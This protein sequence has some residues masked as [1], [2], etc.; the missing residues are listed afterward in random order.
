MFS[1]SFRIAVFFVL[2]SNFCLAQ[3][4][5]NNLGSGKAG[6]LNGI[7]TTFN[8]VYAL[9]GNQSGIANL[10]KFGAFAFAEQRFLLDELTGVTAGVVIPTKAGNFGATLGYFG[11]ETLSEQKIGLAYARKLFKNLSIGGQFDFFNL[12]TGDF[13]S[14]STFTFEF[15]MQYEYSKK[16]TLGMHTL[17]PIRAKLNEDEILASNL[18]IGLNYKFIETATLFAEFEKDLNFESSFRGGMTYLPTPNLEFRAA[19]RTNPTS[20]AF[21]AGYQMKSGFGLDLAANYHQILGFT[22]SAGFIYQISQ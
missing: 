22:P 2:I 5:F 6:G 1:M 11:F 13:G 18:K 3:G 16:L 20:F 7:N 12:Q 17:N 8:D 4:V 15:G 21:G 14:A 9:A 19:I 10:K